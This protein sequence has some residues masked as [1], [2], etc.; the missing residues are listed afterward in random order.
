M[1]YYEV[2]PLKIIHGR[3]SVLTYQSTSLY[4]IGMIVTVPVGNAA[5]IAAIVQR[6][7]EKPVF[8]TRDIIGPIEDM[9]LPTSLVRLGKWLA[10]F[11][12]THPVT[13]WQTMLP[14]GLTKTR[15]QTA[16]ASIHPSRTRT[17]IVL[18]DEQSLAVTSIMSSPAGTTLLHGITGSGKTAVYIELARQTMAQGRSAILLVPEIALTS[19]LIAEFKPH[20]PDVVVTHSTMTES[21]RHTTWQALLRATSPQIVIGPRSALFSPVPRLGLIMIDECHEMTFKQEQSPRYSALRAAAMR[22][23][24]DDARLVL[25]SATPNVTDYYLAQQS[26][27]PILQ[28]TKPARAHTVQPTITLVD[29][30]KPL[31]FSRHTFF[32]NDMLAAISTTLEHKHQALLFHNRRGTAPSTLCEHCGW[33]ALCQRCYVPLTLH[34]DSFELRCHICNHRERVPTSCLTCGEAQIIHKGIGTKLIH[35]EIAKLFPH[36]R[37][38]RFDGDNDIE[39]TL[40][41]QYQALYDG[42]IDIIIG[43]QVVAKGLDLPNL[44]MVGVIQADAGLML[45]DYI[46]SE[47]TFQLLAQVCGR[48][49]RNEHVSRVVVQ[50]Y[51]PA[52]PAVSYGITS[53]YASFYDMTISERK[54]AHFP[55]FV[56][57]AKL[58]CVYKTEEAAIRNSQ[59]LARYLRSTLPPRVELLGP[60]PCFYERVR[61]TYRWQIIVKSPQRTDLVEI[62][63]NHLPPTNWL[64]ELDPASLL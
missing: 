43:T 29:M 32:S 36:A 14:R 5:S 8:V 25:G 47:R 38:S 2:T 13:V 24:Y 30:T 51:Q 31:N 22:A 46:A 56:H 64:Y 28:L 52:H 58:I 18:N 49:G 34:A 53:D 4:A 50:S 11:Y 26:A 63:R 44:R 15:R 45:P 62:I 59:K 6:Q 48:V 20:F 19:Q 42:D 7:V 23:R 57:L 37:I 55:P 12:A 33:S 41:K 17:H 39:T 10:E 1:Y 3:E 9:P 40:D 61:D 21:Q 35:Q 54:R 27:R 60:T 16:H